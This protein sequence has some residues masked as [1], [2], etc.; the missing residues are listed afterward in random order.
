MVDGDAAAAAD[1]VAHVT[2]EMDDTT[3][4]PLADSAAVVE[5]SAEAVIEGAVADDANAL[6]GD[7]SSMLAAYSAAVA[8]ETQADEATAQGS[9]SSVAEVE[10]SVTENAP[11]SHTADEKEETE[12]QRHAID[13]TLPASSATPQADAANDD[14]QVRASA[15]V[16]SMGTCLLSPHWLTRCRRLNRPPNRPMCCGQRTASGRAPPPRNHSRCSRRRRVCRA[17]APVRCARRA[18]VGR[19]PHSPSSCQ[20]SSMAATCRPSSTIKRKR[21]TAS[22]PSH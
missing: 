18:A 4:A 8:D 21:T 5:E 2:A 1:R 22:P 20:N 7:D 14:V 9:A 15:S 12:A 10:H 13:S 3:E 6:K 11:S 19:A 16:S 17:R